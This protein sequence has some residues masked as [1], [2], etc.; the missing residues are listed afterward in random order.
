MI[1]SIFPI[2][3]IG[4]HLGIVVAA[5]ANIHFGNTIIAQRAHRLGI[6]HRQSRLLLNGK[7][8]HPCVRGEMHFV[9]N[10]LI[11]MIRKPIDFAVTAVNG[12]CGCIGGCGHTRTS[13]TGIEGTSPALNVARFT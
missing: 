1:I 5:R 6:I 9:K 10:Q 3:A 4:A 2:N 8:V 12:P 7:R 11:V 13:I